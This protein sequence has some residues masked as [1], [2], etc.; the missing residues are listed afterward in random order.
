MLAAI[1]IGLTYEERKL[2][3]SYCRATENTLLFQTDLS[4]CHTYLLEMNQLLQ[5]MDVL[6]RTYSAPAI[7]AMQVCC[8]KTKPKTD[9]PY[10][11]KK[12][13]QI[14]KNQGVSYCC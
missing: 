6:H 7:N 14:L 9:F 11:C 5:S 10:N 13:P 12:Q 4:N 2:S 1:K 8:L 3:V